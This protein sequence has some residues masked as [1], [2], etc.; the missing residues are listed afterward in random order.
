MIPDEEHR[1][2]AAAGDFDPRYDASFQRGYRP[3]PGEKPRRQVR[4]ATASGPRA[5]PA[6]AETPE[7]VWGVPEQQSRPGAALPEAAALSIA[8]IPTAVPPDSLPGHGAPDVRERGAVA[9]LLDRLE[10]SPRRN[11][12]I[13]ALW[14]IGGGFVVLG[15]VLYCVSVS[16][17]YA[18]PTPSS[19][20]GSLVVAQ[21]GWML[22]G[23]LITIGLATLVA[24]LFLTALV[25]RSHSEHASM[26]QDLDEGEL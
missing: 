3:Q 13:L 16:I 21:L 17:S 22:A 11:P 19:D 7:P 18:G 6:P 8:P 2:A 10:L 4:S 24:L 23:P 14:L 26:D 5:V 1:D 9:S 15:I 20:V 12:F 25:A